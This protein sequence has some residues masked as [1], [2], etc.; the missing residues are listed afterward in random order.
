MKYVICS[1]IFVAAAMVG[2]AQPLAYSKD[3]NWLA[4]PGKTSFADSISKPLVGKFLKDTS[5]DVFFIYP[6]IYTDK[7]KPNGWFASVTDDAFIQKIQHYENLYGFI[8]KGVHCYFRRRHLTSISYI[9][10]YTGK[11]IYRPIL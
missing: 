5:V 1:V 8:I 2:F 10:H 11:Y 4:K 3:E 7:D 9:F 6:T